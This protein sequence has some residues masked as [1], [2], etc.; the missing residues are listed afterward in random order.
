MFRLHRIDVQLADSFV[1]FDDGNAGV[2]VDEFGVK[3]PDDVDG[4]IAFGDD[5]GH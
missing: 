5:A 2:V 4:K 3:E 1:G